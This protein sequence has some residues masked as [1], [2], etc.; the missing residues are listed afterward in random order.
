MDRQLIATV[1]ILL[2]CRS[3]ADVRAQTPSSCPDNTGNSN[4]GCGNRGDGNVGYWNFGTGN[5]GTCNSG[6]G[7]VGTGQIGQ[8]GAPGCSTTCPAGTVDLNKPTPAPGTPC[9]AGTSFQL[10]PGN[11]C[12]F[13]LPQC[14]KCVG[15]GGTMPATTPVVTTA[16]TTTPTATKTPVATPTATVAAIQ[17]P[18]DADV[19]N[20]ALQLEYLEANFYWCA[21]YGTPIDTKYWLGGPAPTGCVKGTY[22]PPVLA[23]LAEIA[24]DELS[25]VIDLQAALGA[26]AV[27]Q[28]QIDLKDALNAAAAAAFNTTVDKF[29][30]FDY[31]ASDLGGLIASVVFEDVGVT[32][33]LGA[34][35]S[36]SSKAI[37]EAAA[38]ILAI[39]AYH[40]GA[41]RKTLF[42]M[43]L[44]VTPYKV[45]V[46]DIV[47]AISALREAVSQKVKA[48]PGGTD[49]GLT[50]VVNGVVTET[51]IPAGPG[52]IAFS[53][54]TNQVI[55]IVT[56]GAANRKGGFFPA[57]LN[58]YI[59]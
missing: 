26:A 5:V 8:G 58:G 15:S 37:L 17:R 30:G 44:T 46:I 48:T 12:D 29:A 43:G 39:E 32:A 27:P 9:P 6:S 57:G 16:P 2:V 20:F 41:V 50:T 31:S 4:K 24:D 22:S 56:L 25:H 36:I 54:N 10:V 19:L 52:A 53:R 40:A 13:G 59:S 45:T 34:A 47:N 3:A 21:V 28:P 33:Y 49:Q 14:C 11:Q 18:T 55:A 38:G 51:I 7:L 1:V 23:F 35:S 42:D